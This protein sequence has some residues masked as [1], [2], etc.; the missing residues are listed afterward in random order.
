MNYALRSLPIALLLLAETV[1]AASFNTVRIADSLLRPVFLTA[2]PGDSD[3]LFVL[4]QH[5]GRIMVMNSS[6]YAIDPTPF[7]TVDNLAQGSEQ[8]LLGMSFHPDYQNN[9]NFYLNY[10]DNTGAT[11]ITRYQVSADPSIAN[12]ASATPVLSYAQPQANHNGGWIGFGPDGYLYIS[13]GDGGGSFDSGVEHD[14]DL[15]NAQ[16]LDS[17]LGKMLRVDV[18]GDDF[19][20]DAQRNYAIPA[21]NPFV[22]QDGANEIW[23]YGLRNPWRASFDRLTGDLYIG[24]VGQG[25]R[26][27]INVQPAG[28]S[29]GE[30]YGWRLRE[31]TIATPGD[32]G[33]EMPDGAIDPI[34]DYSRGIGTL[35][36]FAV[37][38][39]YVYRG[40]IAELQGLYFFADYVNDRI[41]S[42]GYDGS[43]PTTFD[44]T[45]YSNFI[46]WT[47]LLLPDAGTLDQIASFGE[48]GLG[49]LYIVGL[50]G[51]IFTL[52]PV[53]LPGALLL[54][55]GGL[56]PLLAMRLRHERVS[57]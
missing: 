27:E 1:G 55:L 35:Q 11:R 54:L 2:A 41:W 52:Q 29:G 24:D 50:D 26:E 45:N 48:D 10:T 47:D 17:L 13:S 51:E 36:G 37:T 56:C 12:A 4:E 20:A 32:V 22:G 46:D 18:D 34:Y 38:G 33:G 7:L 30:N 43:D 14:A 53:P 21:S 42:L 31:G 40:P 6:T 8:G 19:A 49:N 39:G 23:S 15:G 5:S 3:R 16:D 25:A 57:A 28:S 44:G 9:G